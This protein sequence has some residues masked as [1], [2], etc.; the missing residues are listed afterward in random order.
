MH[1]R[2]FDLEMGSTDLIIL[3]DLVQFPLETR[4]I[5][6]LQDPVACSSITWLMQKNE[7]ESDHSLFPRI[8]EEEKKS[9]KG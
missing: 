4:D 6:I 8:Q 2:V 9:G 3:N 5:Q 7:V 1:L